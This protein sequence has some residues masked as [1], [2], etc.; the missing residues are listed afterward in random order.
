MGDRA[1]QH[2][3]AGLLASMPETTAP[4]L[5]CI[6]TTLEDAKAED[7]TTIDIQDKSSIGDAMII[8]SGRS[9]RHVSAITDRVLRDL[10][11]NGFGSAKVEGTPQCDWVL[12]DTGDIV[13]H[14]FRPE[15][16]EFYN[17]EKMWVANVSETASAGSA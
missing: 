5:Q 11:E 6:L 16:R 13:L 4:S 17:L 9:N 2:D 12:V 1:L 15:V 8:A 14:I 3:F 7:I 10:K